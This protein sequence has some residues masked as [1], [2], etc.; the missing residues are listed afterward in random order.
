MFVVLSIVLAALAAQQG[1]P[2]RIDAN[3]IAPVQA[4]AGEAPPSAPFTGTPVPGQ[5]AVQGTPTTAPGAPTAP[6]GNAAGGVP[7]AQ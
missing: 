6:A 5:P 4:P 1:G 7:I 2:R 3:A